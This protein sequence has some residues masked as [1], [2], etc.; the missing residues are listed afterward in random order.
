MKANKRNEATPGVATRR[1]LTAGTAVA[2]LAPTPAVPVF[3]AGSLSG[4]NACR[5]ANL[6]EDELT[7]TGYGC[8]PGRGIFQNEPAAY[9]FSRKTRKGQERLTRPPVGIPNP[10]A[11]SFNR[12]LTSHGAPSRNQ[13]LPPARGGEGSAPDLNPAIHLRQV[14]ET[15]PCSAVIEERN[16]MAREIHDT[17]AQEFAGILLHLE[18]VNG[19]DASENVSEYLA[20]AR[21]LA[22]SGLEDAR[23]MLLGL[24][25]KSLEGAHLSDALNQLAE[26]FSRDCGINCAF[27]ASG[28]THKL[29][30]EIENELYRVAQEA[31]CN[32]RKHSRAGSVSILL[33]YTSAGVVLAIKDNGQGFA[34]KQPEP[35]AHGFGLPAMCERA[36]RL[37]GRMDINSGQG[38][39]TEIRMSVPLSGEAS[40]ERNNQ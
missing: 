21:E 24:R 15:V 22:K 25:P 19:L 9:R 32:V 16:R 13:A 18:A 4:G 11:K 1:K 7:R 23:R 34:M 2:A 35:G 36:S 38:T 8:L 27:S 20:R 39:G 14:V 29:P 37:G 31:L 3:S 6:G 26:R 10:R 30:E 12:L 5:T 40:K 28:R 17:L 33:S